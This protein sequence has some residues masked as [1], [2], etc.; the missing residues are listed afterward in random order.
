MVLIALA[1]PWFALALMS[2]GLL[3]GGEARIVPLL[4]VSLIAT[5]VGGWL[6]LLLITRT[7]RRTFMQALT[8]TL[9]LTTILLMLELPAA[10]RWAHWDL[11]FR[12]LSGEGFD[13]GSAYVLDEELSFRRIPGLRWS[14]RPLSDVEAAYGLP[15]SLSDPITFTYDRWGYRNAADI[16]HAEVVL[17]GDSYVEGWYVSDEQTVAAQLETSLRSPVASLGVAGYGTMQAL[18]VLEGDALLRRPRIAAWF[19]FEGNDLYD[20][21]SFENGLL[22]E[23]PSPEETT[24]HPQGLTRDH[25]WSQRS[26]TLNAFRRLRRWVHPVIPNQAPYRAHLQDQP[27]GEA[28]YFFDYGSVPWTEYEEGQ[29]AKA[30]DT[31]QRGLEFARARNIHLAFLFVP[32]KYRVYKDVIDIPEG[33]PL[34]TW[35]AWEKL[36]AH[37]QDFCAMT[38]A[39]CL[40]LTG[41]LT[42]SVRE[43]RVPFAPTDTHWNP[44]GHAVAAAELARLIRELGW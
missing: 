16:E 44:R 18:R 5:Y 13:Y 28:V 31:F 14:G 35:G 8:T 12:D 9:T 1:V 20:D 2:R 27:G 7:R 33:S 26:F 25:G 17:L 37:F 40:D 38:S 29:W 23:P 43:G 42:Q 3:P 11:I 41:P 36:P 4:G 24:P 15:R 30:R 6:F 10:L 21:Q 39:A 19:F 32:T 22:A 34:E